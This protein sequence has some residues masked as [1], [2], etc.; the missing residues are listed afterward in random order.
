MCYPEKYHSRYTNK[1]KNDLLNI[2]NN[3]LTYVR[4]VVANKLDLC[5]QYTPD[6]LQLQTHGLPYALT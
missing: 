2:Q 4:E 1:H 6:T 3:L 5:L